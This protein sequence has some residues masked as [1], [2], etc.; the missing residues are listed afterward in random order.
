LFS[1]EER[2][3][4]GTT[5]KQK[6]SGLAVLEGLE[7]VGP[8]MRQMAE[9]G[10]S[11][12]V[13]KQ[14]AVHCWR[15]GQ[16]SGSVAWLL[17][18]CGIDVT[19]LQ[20]GYKS[21]RRSIH[22][23]FEDL[24]FHLIVL[25]GRTGSR[26]TAVL[27]ALREMGEQVVDL[28]GLA[29]HKGSAF[30]WINEQDQPTTQ[31]FE[32]DLYGVMRSFDTARP[33]WLENESKTI[34]KVYLND[35]LWGAMKSSTLIHM[36][37]DLD[38]RLDHLVGLYVGNDNL[39]DLKL[40]FTKITKRLGGQ[41]VKSAHEALDSGDYRRAAEIALSYYDKTYDY[42]LENNIS[43]DIRIVNTGSM[44]IEDAAQTV[45]DH[46]REVPVQSQ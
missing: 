41:H 27:H 22:A 32:N 45:L 46:M 6:G 17:S 15:G 39:D 10:L 33:V 29:N 23:L 30:G 12:A 9:D 26:K 21:Y 7:I 38:T 40:S 18:K 37:V 20:G 42:N 28:E 1:D 8:R 11:L 2:A 31:Q 4:I 3:Q 35:H 13:D 5:Y 14:I 24:P 36:D 25:G 19:V 44:S 16:R 34:G 43:P